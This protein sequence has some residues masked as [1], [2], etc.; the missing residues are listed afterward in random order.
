MSPKSW[1]VRRIGRSGE[2][3]GGPI[4]VGG[5]VFASTRADD[6]VGLRD[7]ILRIVW[8]QESRNETVEAL[9]ENDLL[10]SNGGLGG[11]LVRSARDG[12][13]LWSAPSWGSVAR[14]RGSAIF[15]PI[16]VGSTLLRIEER[17]ARTGVLASVIEAPAGA[18]AFLGVDDRNVFVQVDTGIVGLARQGGGETWRMEVRALPPLHGFD[19]PLKTIGLTLFESFGIVSYNQVTARLDLATGAVRWSVPHWS[20]YTSPTVL[21]GQ[22]VIV[23]FNQVILLDT[24]SG[25]VLVRKIHEALTDAY[26][27][28]RPTIYKGRIAISYESGHVAVIDGITGDLVNSVRLPKPLLAS[29]EHEGR[30]VVSTADGTL[31]ISDEALWGL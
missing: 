29:A 23:S 7:S 8:K 6:V 3:V 21:A 17:A 18:S 4:A 12:A 30:L 13:L 24:S 26:R 15:L 20:A 5:C 10:V 31:M 1:R 19:A 9:A 25:E 11:V 27:E 2:I 16:G 28:E 14:V 22:V